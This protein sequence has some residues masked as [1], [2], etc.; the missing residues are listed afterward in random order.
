[1]SLR[2]PLVG[3]NRTASRRG[4]PTKLT[5]TT[6]VLRQLPST[7]GVPFPQGKLA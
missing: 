4:T 6:T 3:V 2:R 1:M 5:S 7:L